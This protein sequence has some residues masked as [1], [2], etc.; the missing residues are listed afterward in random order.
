MM[1]QSDGL[2][3]QANGSFIKPA[4][5]GNRPVPIHFSDD[6]NAEVIMKILRRLPDQMG[7]FEIPGKRS[8]VCARVDGGMIFVIDPFCQLFV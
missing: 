7:M 5:Q 1:Q 6:V 8:L 3:D 4:A 2:S